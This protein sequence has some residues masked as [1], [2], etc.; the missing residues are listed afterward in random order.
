MTT[1][2]EK[3]ETANGGFLKAM[4]S[5]FA[6]YFA[7]VITVVISVLIYLEYRQFNLEQE[8]LEKQEVLRLELASRI[9]TQDLKH[10]TVD[11]LTIAMLEELRVYINT[12]SPQSKEQLERFF[13]NLATNQGFYDQIRV[14]DNSG[15]ETIR[16]NYKNGVAVSVPLAQLQDKSSRYY[17][18]EAMT[19]D[20][21]QVFIS[22]LDLNVEHG[23]VETPYKPMLRIAT[24]LFGASG[25]RQGILVLNYLAEFLQKHFKDAMI[26]SWGQPMLVNA[27]GQWLYS[28]IS[29]NEWGFML[30]H[31]QTFGSHFPAAWEKILA[32]EDAGIVQTKDG[33]FVF[34]TL[35]PAR[36][37]ETVP[38]VRFS[39]PQRELGVRYW[40]LISHVPRQQA[41]F[42]PASSLRA[43]WELVLAM[44]IVSAAFS[45][46][47]AHFR[48]RNV[49]YNR[50]LRVSEQR[51]RLL[52]D[53]VAEGIFG[54]DTQG[55]CTFV[56]PGA[57]RLL[58][59]KDASD[60]VHHNIHSL[61]HHS[62]PD[63]SPCTEQQC[64]IY[65]AFREGASYHADDECL[66]RA[67]GTSFPVEY[68]STPLLENGRITG[69]VATFIDVTKRKQAENLLHRAHDEMEARVR[70]RTREL[71][72]ANVKLIGEVAER[73]RA[74]Q[75][76]TEERNFV[77]AVLSTVGALV[78]VL[79]AQGRVVRFNTACEQ[80]TGYSFEE[81]EGKPVWDYLLLA[82]EVESVKGVFQKLTAGDF[83][84]YYDNYWLTK[85]GRRPLISWSNTALIKPE[86]GKV[87]YV[88]ATGIDITERKQAEE[89]LRDNEEQ[90]R[91]I[92]D[93]LPVV[94]SYLD[95]QRRY[96]F[97]NRVFEQWF[98]T[99]RDKIY[100]KHIREV[101]GEAAYLSI[102]DKIAQV[103]SGTAVHFETMV[104]YKTAGQ[105]Y[106]S[107]S[108]VPHIDQRGQVKG[109]FAL[110]Q[111]ITER[112]HAEE[113]ARQHQEEL[114]HITRV[115]T[116]GELATGLAHELNQPLTAIHTYAEIA[117]GMA[118][119]REGPA[120]A[121][122]FD[123]ALQGIM[124]QAQRASNIVNRLREFVRKRE[125]S[126]T[127][128]DL[129]ELIRDV[130][131]FVQPDLQRYSIELKL[132]LQ[133]KLPATVADK[134]QIEQVLL[135]LLRNSIQA[136]AS[137]G[138]I[139]RKLTI[140]SSTSSGNVLVEVS[141][142]GPG[143]E[144]ETLDKIFESF[145]STKGEAGMG[146]GLSISRSIM[147][148]HHGSLWA[149]S[150]PG[151]GATFYIR[152]PV[153][154]A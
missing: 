143:M 87:E 76:L 150:E 71:E 138:N 110:I 38:H 7:V 154:D 113:Q 111:D 152:L 114:A 127:S 28:S 95:S 36:V 23:V 35:Y 32:K 109:F 12:K 88:I 30:G 61:I 146:L 129:N 140:R 84:S 121:E 58:G 101:L 39:I 52:L 74:Q 67:D 147:E 92:T 45:L 48:T 19:L 42:G 130:L 69:A 98:E 148:A 126:V 115:N 82:E 49:I 149:E 144:P 78:I 137:G 112:K 60:L 79:D 97:N 1:E 107:A 103:L 99:R 86:T 51:V 40:K 108:Y 3:T 133:P 15:L 90:L 31:G 63:G 117:L 75:A 41:V 16:I 141:D 131:E 102:K 64:R 116:M 106:V 26:N 100:G 53:S 68:W 80:L 153:D 34:H 128:L 22:P 135:N 136:M 2:T 27:D 70:E 21:G 47:L 93:S 139:K 105:R 145:V 119:D 72:S 73:E 85:G 17:F 94:I 62:H 29:N 18:R 5:R 59:Y 56:N 123:Q 96:R 33:L 66:W 83:P 9:L 11:S 57:V 8:S 37:L 91:L 89:A 44:I 54:V 118:A 13:L 134:I 55:R 20:P 14:I 124:G 43:N 77:T 25:N 6:V 46:L 125:A 132:E 50:Q 142:S 24:P 104:P 122:D 4:L 65:S 120:I 10:A 151:Q 81:L